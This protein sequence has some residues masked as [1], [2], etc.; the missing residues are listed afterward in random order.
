MSS[1]SYGIGMGEVSLE[2]S[3]SRIAWSWCVLP[4]PDAGMARRAAGQAYGRD[5][6]KGDPSSVG[7]IS[8]V[9]YLWHAASVTASRLWRD[10][11]YWPRARDLIHFFAQ[12][13]EWSERQ[14]VKPAALTNS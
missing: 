14:Q 4:D 6:P 1:P 5:Q 10:L 13:L 11:L 2:Q 7:K 8:H 9:C 12:M 3:L